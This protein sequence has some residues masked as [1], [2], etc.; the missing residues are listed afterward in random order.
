MKHIILLPDGR[1]ISS[2]AST[3]NAIQS[4]SKVYIS[5]GTLDIQ[6]TKDDTYGVV[7]KVISISGGSGNIGGGSDRGYAYSMHATD[8]IT[9]SGGSINVDFGNNSFGSIE[10]DADMVISGGSVNI[11][12]Y[13]GLD[14][15][16]LTISGGIVDIS[17]DIG[18]ISARVAN[19][20]GGMVTKLQAAKICMNSG[21]EMIIANGSRPENLYDIMDGLEVGTKF[22]GVRV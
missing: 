5:G 20:T 22:T 1:E 7:A 4:A 3:G 16:K 21:C 19:F 13:H 15:D 18:S 11:M 6:V 12:S 2:G 8:K 9:I 10:C 14:A 17:T